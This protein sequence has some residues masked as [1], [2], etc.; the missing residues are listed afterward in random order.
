MYSEIFGILALFLATAVIGPNAGWWALVG[1]TRLLFS[2][3]KDVAVESDVI[4]ARD[5]AV[6]VASFNEEKAL[7]LC[8]S[9]ALVLLPANQVFIANDAS[10]DQTANIALDAGCNLYTAP[11]N[12]GK[13]RVLEAT[14]K[15]FQLLKR[16]R[17]ILFLD[18]DSQID[19]HYLERAL[20]ILSD[21]RNAVVAGHV[22]SRAPK[23]GSAVAWMIHLYRSRLYYCV[24]LIFRYGQ[25]WAPFNASFIAPGFASI[26]RSEVIEQINISAPGLIIEDFNM[27]FEVHRKSLG[28]V[29]YSPGVK[30]ATED[31]VFLNDYL[32]QIRRWNLGLWQTV[33]HNGIWPSR[34]WL[35]FLL[36]QAEMVFFS[37]AVLAIVALAAMKLLFGIHFE[38]SF[39]TPFG[40]VF[41]S[42]YSLFAGLIISDVMLSLIF[43]VLAQKWRTVPFAIIFPFL[44]VMDAYWMIASLFSSC[45]TRSDG[46]W[47]S[48]QRLLNGKTV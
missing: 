22:E 9:H 1:L 47:N 39:L 12:V 23:N 6:V 37:L 21:P 15:H 7:P 26:Y 31:P 13:A 43:A 25:T 20:P 45:Y 16:F 8:I 5:V 17:A 32:K 44:R 33:K 29:A 27:T 2:A 28:R 4:Q 10:S 18:A 14:I 24:Q 40:P 19:R 46:R 38:G 30:C 41:Y 42:P 48:P 35:F 11:Q 3:R 34:F 36:L